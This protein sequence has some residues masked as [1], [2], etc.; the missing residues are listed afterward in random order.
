MRASGHTDTDGGSPRA[1]K[2]VG[3][4]GVDARVPSPGPLPHTGCCLLPAAPGFLGEQHW[5]T[6]FRGRDRDS[7]NPHTQIRAPERK[8]SLWQM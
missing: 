7:S 1:L 2:V 5:P 8:G 3:L 6:P 4:A